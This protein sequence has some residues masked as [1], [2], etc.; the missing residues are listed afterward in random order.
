MALA[1][2]D[3]RNTLPIPAAVYH[4]VARAVVTVTVLDDG[5]NAE[6]DVV[7]NGITKQIHFTVPDLDAADTAELLLHDADNRIIYASGEKAESTTHVINVERALCGTITFRVE[8]SASQ[9]DA[10]SN[11]FTVCVYYV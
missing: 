3:D 1:S 7:L 11:V 10:A 2:Y 5:T 9:E 6:T 4:P 8:C